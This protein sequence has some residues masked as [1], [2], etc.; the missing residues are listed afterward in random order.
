MQYTTTHI[1]PKG[2]PVSPRHTYKTEYEG[3]EAFFGQRPSIIMPFNDARR[4]TRR[5]K[6]PN[7][8]AYHDYVR[9]FETHKQHTRLPMRPRRIWN[10]DIW[11]NW[12]DYLGTGRIANKNRVFLPYKEALAFVHQLG[13][14]GEKEWK[15]FA[16]S[17]KRPSTIPHNPWE[18]YNEYVG[19]KAWVGTDVVQQLTTRNDGMGVL[20][21]LHDPFDPPN[22]F[23]YQ[24]FKGGK[25]QA[26]F[27]CKN[28][29]NIVRTYEYESDYMDEVHRIIHQSST[30]FCDQHFTAIN[31]NEICFLLDTTLVI[32]H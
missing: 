9:N 13:L 16:K 25:T 12:G 5:L 19:I 28:N 2:F 15:L 20:C 10:D 32:V 30:G 31:F 6:L 3:D 22:V 26:E 4:I 18:V 21:L 23:T 1:L 29:L 11:T 14:K 17:D 27:L 8:K 24:I 7:V